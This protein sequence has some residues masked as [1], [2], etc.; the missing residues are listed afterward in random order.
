MLADG[1]AVDQAPCLDGALL[2]VALAL[3][4]QAVLGRPEPLR[5]LFVQDVGEQLVQAP[6][7][8]RALDLADELLGG[9]QDVGEDADG[10]LG[11]LQNLLD[12]AGECYYC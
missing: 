10:Y 9:G 4:D 11:V 3:D 5:W 2:G 8:E 7:L 1:L 6:V 12:D